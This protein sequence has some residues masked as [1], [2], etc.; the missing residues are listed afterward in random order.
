MTIERG[1]RLAAVAIAVIGIVDPSVPLRRDV[2]PSVELQ[3]GSGPAAEVVRRRLVES[4]HQA[5]SFNDRDE[6]VARV[7]IGDGPDAIQSGTDRLPVSTV[8]LSTDSVPNVRIASVSAPHRVPVGW[9]AAVTVRL[10][11]RG[12]RGTTSRVSLEQLGVELSKVEHKWTLD[13]E[14]ANLVIRYA[15]PVPGATRVSVRVTSAAPNSGIGDNTSELVLRTTDRRLRVLVYEPRPSWAAAFIRRT[16]EQ[17]AAFD[18]T[19]L[20]RPSRG[21][22]VTAGVAPATLSTDALR[23]YDAVLVG[24]PEELR[25]ADVDALLAFMRIRGGSLIVVPDRRP[26]GPFLRL[27]PT[28]TFDE[29]LVENPLD[30]K[31]VDA[32][33]AATELVIPRGD[34]RGADI[35]AAVNMRGATQPVIF[36]TRIGQGQVIFSG[37]LDAWRFR[38]SSGSGFATFWTTRIAEAALAAPQRL[39]V[40][41]TPAIAA[42]GDDVTV[43]VRVRPTEFLV[44]PNVTRISP[45]AARIVGPGGIDRPIRLWPSAETGVLI[46]RLVAPASG[47]YDVQVTSTGATADV[48]LISADRAS[49]PL[50]APSAERDRL[51]LIS[52]ATGGVTATADDLSAL[53]H[54]LRS[55]GNAKRQ[56]AAHPSRSIWFVLAFAGLVCAEWALRRR[57]GLA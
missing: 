57:K 53:T 3:V 33:L 44:S 11:G 47:T 30:V 7:V 37:A 34:T 43:H 10:D 49:T 2:L 38:A 6:A 29:A 40:A 9:T 45:T 17:N 20:A 46:G 4:L 18:V 51:R 22:E 19:A 24:A 16:L 15:P 26:S 31:G 36:A 21:I 5:V 50:R 35:L 54:H 48:E 41:L 13:S 55:L 1:L 39:E 52:D 27:L 23:T 8:S 28:A 56:E 14:T 32:T 12:M 25:S 42:P